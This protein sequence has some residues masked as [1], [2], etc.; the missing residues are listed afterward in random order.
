MDTN[1]PRRDGP[2]D[3]SLNKRTVLLGSAAG[4][5]IGALLT[6]SLLP[7]PRPTPKAPSAQAAVVGSQGQPRKQLPPLCGVFMRKSSRSR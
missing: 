6:V 5:L 3:P 4:G 2:E 7:S 1:K